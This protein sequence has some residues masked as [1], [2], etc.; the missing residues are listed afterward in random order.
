MYPQ[1]I[2]RVSAPLPPVEQ[3]IVRLRISDGC[4]TCRIEDYAPV[5]MGLAVVRIG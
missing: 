1:C 5:G 3:T 2:P 4:P